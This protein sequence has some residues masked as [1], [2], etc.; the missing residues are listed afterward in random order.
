MSVVSF[1]LAVVIIIS[2]NKSWFKNN[3]RSE[4]NQRWKNKTLLQSC[5][6]QWEV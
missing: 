3:H 5:F 4:Q 2:T 6:K 1:A